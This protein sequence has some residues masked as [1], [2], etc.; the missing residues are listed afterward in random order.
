MRALALLWLISISAVVCPQGI[1]PQ[2]QGY[3][4]QNRPKGEGPAFVIGHAD[5]VL[6]G[7]GPRTV[8][9]Y[10]YQ[11]GEAQDRVHRQYL[12]VFSR[13][14]GTYDVSKARLVGWAGYQSFD[15][16]EIRDGRIVLSGRAWKAT[17]PMASPSTV[18]RMTYALL[19]GDLIAGATE[20]R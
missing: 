8:V 4:E 1:D 12:V 15:R 7:F 9:L 16:V 18:V 20:V 2:I 10:S 19:D 11:I 13:I 14:G 17:D 6:E 3:L 5:G